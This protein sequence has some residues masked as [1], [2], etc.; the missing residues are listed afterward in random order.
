MNTVKYKVGNIKY[1]RDILCAR[2]IWEKR[3]KRWAEAGLQDLITWRYPQGKAS[4]T[5]PSWFSCKV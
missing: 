2:T 3:K 1:I 5:Q 4:I